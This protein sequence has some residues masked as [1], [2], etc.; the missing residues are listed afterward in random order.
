[1]SDSTVELYDSFYHPQGISA[2]PESFAHVFETLSRNRE[3]CL[4]HIRKHQT[5]AKSMGS[6]GRCPYWV[7]QRMR[8][9]GAGVCKSEACQKTPLGHRFTG[10]NIRRLAD[11]LFERRPDETY[12]P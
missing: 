11:G 2:D 3:N 7:L 10:V 8:E 6:A 1:Y 9:V 12:R 5:G 4:E